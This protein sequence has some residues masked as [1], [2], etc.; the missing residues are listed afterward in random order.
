MLHSKQKCTIGSLI[1]CAKDAKDS[2]KISNNKKVK[3]EFK[4]NNRGL[5]GSKKLRW[6]ACDKEK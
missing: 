5:H 6:S 2:L 3:L 1:D 4:A